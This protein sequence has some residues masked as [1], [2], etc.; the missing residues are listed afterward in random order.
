MLIHEPNKINKAVVSD[1]TLPARKGVVDRLVVNDLASRL[2]VVRSTINADDENFDVV[3]KLE[4]ALVSGQIIDEGQIA[5][6]Y[7]LVRNY[8]R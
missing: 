5:R 4:N 6:A 2:R 7:E 3:S 1:R 8:G